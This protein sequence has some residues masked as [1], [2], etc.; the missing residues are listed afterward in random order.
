MKNGASPRGKA[1]VF[2]SA[3]R[4]FESFRPRKCCYYKKIINKSASHVP[5][6]INTL[7]NIV[8]LIQDKIKLKIENKYIIL[9]KISIILIE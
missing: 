4:R 7:A 8:L 6:R 9:K 3:I 1:A 5:A 2:G